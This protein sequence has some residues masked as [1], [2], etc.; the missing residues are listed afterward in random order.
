MAMYNPPMP[1]LWKHIARALLITALSYAAFTFLPDLF[2]HPE[3][4]SPFAY[5]IAFIVCIEVW[6]LVPKGKR[7]WLYVPVLLLC[8]LA[9]LDESGYGSEVMDI[10]P[11][12]SQS[13]NTEVRDLHNAIAIGIGLLSDWLEEMRW[14]W[15]L[16]AL[17]IAVD[18]VI[19][20]AAVVFGWLQRR[21][22]TARKP[23]P[24]KESALWVTAGFLAAA[25]LLTAGYLLSLPPD[26]RNA[27]LFGYSA[28]RLA[29]ALGV[30]VVGLAPLLIVWRGD[31][32]KLAKRIDAALQT[33]LAKLSAVLLWLTVLA[34]L[35]YQ[36][37][38]PFLFLPDD[39]VRLERITPLV[40]WWLA[41]AVFLLLG[42]RAWRGGLARSVGDFF[43]GIL[44]FFRREP[45]YFYAGFAVFLI[46]IAQ[47][48]DKHLIPIDESLGLW[49]EEVFET[50]G[51]FMFVAAAAYFHKEQSPK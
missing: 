18:A 46:L 32:A 44:A 10:A 15:G 21:G 29:S 14:D 5:A 30:L 49:I 37:Y 38:A 40:L 34:A 39:R 25:S 36:F 42:V 26:P 41:I 7:K 45:S 13:M 2:P 43:S 17:F 6:L 23:G 24:W 28:V 33:P 12:Y 35:A 19:F 22:V 51:A 8:L 9:L 20:A 11:I 50:T 48:N 3:D 27:I 16:F 1:P 4:V 47:L 31:K